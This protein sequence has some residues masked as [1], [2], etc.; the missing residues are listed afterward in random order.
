MNLKSFI[1]IICVHFLTSTSSFA[2]D[3][4]S[5]K[6]KGESTKDFISLYQKYISGIRGNECPMY[7]SCSYYGVDAFSN[8]SF[9]EAFTLTSERLMRCGH[10]H[11]NYNLTLQ[12]NGIKLIDLAP[13]SD[14]P[15]DLIFQGSK[16]YFSYSDTIADSGAVIFIKKLIN[17]GYHQEA[18]LEIMRA[19]FENKDINVELFI[20]KIICL[21][22]LNAYEK[23]L[24]EYEINADQTYKNN[25]SLLFQLATIYYQLENYS[26][27]LIFNNNA[28]NLSTNS[29][30]NAE[31]ITLRGLTQAKESKWIDSE[32]SFKSL[33][34]YESYRYRA[35]A[36]LGILD[37]HKLIT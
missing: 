30:L 20:N 1:I 22:S 26:K 21:K 3:T 6:E 32:N 35:D 34:N 31:L 14:V 8:T 18:L 5:G 11:N 15:D 24:Y 37:H 10:D 23:A 28:F 29:Y 4:K 19:E 9:F 17:E 7:P 13:Y 25:P 12:P 16:F 33:A 36:S 27:S 2:E